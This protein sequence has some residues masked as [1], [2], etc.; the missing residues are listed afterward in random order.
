[1]F[2]VSLPVYTQSI[3]SSTHS[4][5]TF[6]RNTPL[7][8]QTGGIGLNGTQGVQLNSSASS[9]DLQITLS[10]GTTATISFAGATTLGNIIDDLNAPASF[11]RLVTLKDA[12]GHPLL[13]SSG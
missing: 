11:S 10:D 7:A 2:N 9:P 1:D 3:S 4:I 6:D 8:P 12:T 13:D 5:T